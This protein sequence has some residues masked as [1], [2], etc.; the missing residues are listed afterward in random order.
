MLPRS[1]HGPVRVEVVEPT[2]LRLIEQRPDSLVGLLLRLSRD[3]SPRDSAD[4]TRLGLTV[5]SSRGAVLTGRAR[6]RT[7][8][9]LT[10]LRAVQ[11]IEVSMSIAPSLRPMPDRP[12]R[13]RQTRK[14]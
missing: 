8:L 11:W 3:S 5:L 9:Q 12:T 1:A 2:L 14:Q 13:A 10:R 7:A 6:A 4:L